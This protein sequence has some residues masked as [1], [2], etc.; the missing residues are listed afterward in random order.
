MNDVVKPL[1]IG[2]LVVLVGEEDSGGV[3]CNVCEEDTPKYRWPGFHDTGSPI[4]IDAACTVLDLPIDAVP[5]PIATKYIYIASSTGPI[6]L[7]RHLVGVWIKPEDVPKMLA[8]IK[9]SPLVSEL[10]DMQFVPMSKI[11]TDGMSLWPDIEDAQM[12]IKSKAY[13]SQTAPFLTEEDK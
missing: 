12:T 4:E 13:Y 7:A 1:T 3:L 8:Y 10:K 5:I 6:P 11:N 2:L 9:T